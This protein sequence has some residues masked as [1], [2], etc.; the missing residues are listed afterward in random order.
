MTAL[1]RTNSDCKRQTRPLVRE[2]VITAS[3]QLEKNTGRGS[4]V[5]WRHDELIGDKPPVIKKN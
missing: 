5:A 1:A 2:V 3:V 4:Q